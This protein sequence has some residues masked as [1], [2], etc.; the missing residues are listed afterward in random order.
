M[1]AM[2][3]TDLSVPADEDVNAS[4]VRVSALDAQSQREGIWAKVASSGPERMMAYAIRSSV[5]LGDEQGAYFDHFDANDELA[6]HIV[7]YVGREPVGTLRCRCF[8]GFAR[9]EKL[10]IRR[11]FRSYRVLN[12]L[13]RTALRYC[14]AKGYSMLSGI[15]R[16]EVVAFWC[17]KGGFEVGPAVETQYGPLIPLY[18]PLPAFAD[19]A[20]VTPD[21]VGTAVGER[22][23]YAWEGEAL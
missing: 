14:W 18:G 2:Q 15:A 9:V 21:L 19:I 4:A 17:R 23:L 16:P 12:V 5:F 13:V 11:G 10:A 6:A 22:R 7:V 8:A 20:P 1:S 3:G